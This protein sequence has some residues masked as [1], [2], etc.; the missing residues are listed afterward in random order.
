M[1]ERERERER[2]SQVQRDT[3]G[4]SFKIQFGRITK[5]ESKKEREL[6]G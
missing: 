2:F 3:G 1:R 6:V 4:D 5:K